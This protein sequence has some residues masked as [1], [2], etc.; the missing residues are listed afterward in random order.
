MEN[1][2]VNPCVT[3]DYK[4]TTECVKMIV[5][6]YGEVLNIAYI[7]RSTQGRNIYVLKLGRGKRKILFVAA[8]HGREYVSASFL[9][10]STEFY[11]RM[12]TEKS[13]SDAKIQ[14]LFEEYSFYIVPVCNPD[15]VEI[16]LGKEIPCA[17]IPDFCAYTFKDNANGVNINANFPF[18]WQEVP[19]FRHRGRYAASEKETGN[20]MC[21]C[22]KENFEKMISLHSRG[23]CLYWR[24]AGNKEIKGDSELAQNI[25][26]MC[27]LA[28][29][30]VSEDVKAY[31]GG[32]ENWFRYKYGRPAICVELVS[33]ENAPFDLCCRK[34]F[35]Y[36]DWEN[37]KNLFLSVV[38][39][40]I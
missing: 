29:C 23:G 6:R 39:A 22:E 24:D 33:D 11:A 34:F 30:P 20:L 27:R 19:L 7:Y 14:K 4:R 18:E 9:L 17:D 12:C 15:S 1:F 13:I 36:T 26:D 3:Y 40:N 28:I 16:A 38:R 10:Y 32:F 35:E 25:S 37:T 8:I 31:S 5:R 2:A 21:L